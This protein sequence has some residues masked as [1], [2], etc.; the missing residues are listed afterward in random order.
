M[1]VTGRVHVQ[2]LT[3]FVIRTVYSYQARC[4][5]NEITRSRPANDEML[6][7]NRVPRNFINL[8]SVMVQKL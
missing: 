3:T 5:N 1:N 4:S 8:W 7:P 2:I 6:V